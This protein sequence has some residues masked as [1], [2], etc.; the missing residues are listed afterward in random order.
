MPLE[1]CPHMA[2]RNGAQDKARF[3]EHLMYRVEVINK[4]HRIKLGL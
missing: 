2:I 1:A 4:W 3:P